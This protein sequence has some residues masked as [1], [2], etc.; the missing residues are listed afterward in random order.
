MKSCSSSE[1]IA[2][3]VP[4]FIDL[5]KRQS[6]LFQS[7]FN[8]D[9]NACVRSGHPECRFD[10]DGSGIMEQ[11]LTYFCGNAIEC[12]QIGNRDALEVGCRLQVIFWKVFF[13]VLLFIK[14]A[15]THVIEDYILVGLQEEYDATTAILRKMLPYYLGNI[16]LGTWH[17][18]SWKSPY[19][20]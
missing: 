18:I 20:W 11:Q 1:P 14:A 3:D 5:Y 2:K 10:N 19:I 8:L 15:K 4:K 13:F 7:W 12:R 9:F 6:P 17:E 16:T